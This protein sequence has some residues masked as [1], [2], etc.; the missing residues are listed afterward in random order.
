M[1]LY[2]I[3][4]LNAYELNLSYQIRFI[5]VYQKF[6]KRTFKIGFCVQN[7]LLNLCSLAVNSQRLFCS[8]KAGM[9]IRIKAFW[10]TKIIPI[11]F[12]LREFMEEGSPHPLV[13]ALPTLR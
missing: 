7:H 13:I 6:F 9:N 11:I 8:Q 1:C 10:Y 3:L 4:I 5:F 2:G 12:Y